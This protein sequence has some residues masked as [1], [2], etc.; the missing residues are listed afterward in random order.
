MRKNNIPDPN[1]QRVIHTSG[2]FRFENASPARVANISTV[3]QIMK[4]A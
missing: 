1:K 2:Y 4:T 3:A